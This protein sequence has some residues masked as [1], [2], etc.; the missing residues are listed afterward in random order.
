MA[1]RPVSS[2]TSSKVDMPQ[3]V[4]T[5]E[6][7]LRV[8]TFGA[9]QLDWQVPPFTTEDLWKSRTSARTLLKLLLSTPGRQP[10]RRQLAGILGPETD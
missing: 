5:Q 10:S 2:Q 4:D 7:F 9:F 1:N 8:Y 3:S 6:P